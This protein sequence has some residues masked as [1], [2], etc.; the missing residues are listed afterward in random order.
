MAK[1]FAEDGHS[2][3]S[4]DGIPIWTKYVDAFLEKQ[5]LKQ[6]DDLLPLREN[7]TYPDGLKPSSRD[8]FVRYLEAKPHKA[9][10]LSAD[11]RTGWRTGRDTT[12]EAVEGAIA[13]CA[14]RAATPCRAVIID[15][16]PAR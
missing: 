10:A 1:P 12:Q 3:F 2:L 13:N 6:R 11:G 7:V 9:F 4:R 8:D 14:K 16:S 15:D 5:G